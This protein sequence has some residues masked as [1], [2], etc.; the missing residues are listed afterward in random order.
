MTL[1]NA[2]GVGIFAMIFGFIVGGFLSDGIWKLRKK[3][4][5][6]RKKNPGALHEPG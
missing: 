6:R 1:Y 3:W 4:R 2:I 5:D